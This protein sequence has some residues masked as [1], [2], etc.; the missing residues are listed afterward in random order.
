M[1]QPPVSHRLTITNGDK[2]HEIFMSFGLLNRIT[3]HIGNID[4]LP[5]MAVSPE[6]Q[7]TVLVEIFTQRDPKGEATSI[8]TLDEIQVSLEDVDRILDF[9]G[10]HISNFFTLTAEKAQKRAMI[11]HEKMEKMSALMPTKAGS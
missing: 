10:D 7:E 4:Q 2:P 9:V 3:R 8:P 6:L 5:L 11:I 1:I